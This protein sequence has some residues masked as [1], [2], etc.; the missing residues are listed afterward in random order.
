MPAP[1]IHIASIV[2]APF[3]ENSYVAHLEGRTDCLV[4]DPGFEP[5]LIFEYLEKKNLTPSAFLCTHGHSDHIGG[6]EAMKDRWPDVPLLIGENDAALLTDTTLNLSAP[7]GLPFVSPP[8]DQLLK[9][10][11]T[12]EAA[13]ISLE[14]REIPGHSPGH[15]VFVWHAGEPTYVFGGDCL[16]A[17]GIGRWDFPGGSLRQLKDGIRKKMFTLP[18]DT[19]VLP[20]HGPATLIG[21]EKRNNPYVGEAAE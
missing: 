20:G 10:G 19:I 13:G 5:E 18:D 11:E 9:D 6:N 3:Q 4:F 21:E 8:A 17:G 14:V 16:F 15:V 1:E 2:S 7:F 12:Y